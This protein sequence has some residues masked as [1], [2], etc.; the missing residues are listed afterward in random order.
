MQKKVCARQACIIE[1][2][3]GN[4]YFTVSPPRIP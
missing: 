3:V 4:R 1:I 2:E